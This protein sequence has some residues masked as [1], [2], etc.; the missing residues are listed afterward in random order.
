MNC[1]V[2][3]ELLKEKIRDL[4]KKYNS[5][6]KN[7]KEEWKL[8]QEI[9]K[10]EKDLPSSSTESESKWSGDDSGWGLSD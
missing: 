5:T 3:E 9:D 4:R 2:Q 8:K 1:N 6:P 10:L 7:S